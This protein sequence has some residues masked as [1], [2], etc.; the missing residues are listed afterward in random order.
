[1]LCLSNSAVRDV[2]DHLLD[3]EAV[4]LP[5]LEAV[6]VAALRNGF[7]IMSEDGNVVH[8]VSFRDLVEVVGQQAS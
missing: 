8:S 7:M 3:P 2:V 1:L 5:D 6:R 4:E